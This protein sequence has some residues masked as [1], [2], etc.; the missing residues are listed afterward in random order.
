[1]SVWIFLDR[2]SATIT[3]STNHRRQRA[4]ITVDVPMSSDLDAR[5]TPT[6]S[7]T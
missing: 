5:A 3:E 6:G 2:A 4:E 1:M 7:L